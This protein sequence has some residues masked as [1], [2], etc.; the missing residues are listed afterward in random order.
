MGFLLANFQL[1]TPFNSRLG[2]TYGTDRGTDGQT[3]DGHQRLMPHLWGRAINSP[4][5]RAT[6]QPSTR[7][8]LAACGDD[9]RAWDD[10]SRQ[11]RQPEH[12]RGTVANSQKRKLVHARRFIVRLPTPQTARKP[13]WT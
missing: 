9:R 10:I 2:M 8:M 5:C 13:P 4:V 12:A 11:R 1:D 3:D 6:S 7:P